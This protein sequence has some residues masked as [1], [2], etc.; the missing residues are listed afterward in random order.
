MVGLDLDGNPGKDF[1]KPLTIAD[2]EP[3]GCIMAISP[4]T[5]LPGG[6]E[7]ATAWPTAA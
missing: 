2:G 4:L 1:F 3:V 7:P 5:V 6:S